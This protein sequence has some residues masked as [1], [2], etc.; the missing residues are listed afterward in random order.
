[1]LKLVLLSWLIL[2]WTLS[3]Q[4]DGDQRA[5]INAEILFIN[6]SIH[7]LLIAHRVYENYNQ[8]INKYVDL[9]SYEINK[10]G[11]KDLPKDIFEDPEHWFYERSPQE[12]YKALLL[13]ERRES[14]GLDTWPLIANIRNTGDF[15]NLKRQS[16]DAVI[17]KDNINEMA[18]IQQ[19]YT[20][21]EE[22]IDQYDRVRNSIK[23]FES[24][25]QPLYLGIELPEPEKAIYTTLVEIHYDIKKCLRNIRKDNQSGVIQSIGK[26]DTEVNW[27]SV[28]INKVADT[29]QKA[30]LMR[31]R[32]IIGELAR[33]IKAYLNG[34]NVPQEY[35]A[36][37]KGYYYHNVKLL[38]QVNRYGNGYVAEANA[39]FDKNLW[40]VIHFIEEP[41]YLKIVYPEKVPKEILFDNTIEPTLDVKSLKPQDLPE[42]PALVVESEI[43][44]KEE[45]P[46]EIPVIIVATHTI[47]VDSV[48]FELDL[49]DHKRKDGD[50]VSINVNGEW[51][52]QNISLEK[53]TQKIKLTIKPG[54]DNAIM[55]RADNEGWMPPNTVGLKYVGKSG[56]ENNQF[57]KTDLRVNEVLRI[58]YKRE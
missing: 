5:Y 55:I 42:I 35:G 22:A 17:K 46:K 48:T 50:R 26:I 11:N 6:E 49:L 29:G 10:Y 9:P 37:G 40:P 43:P 45:I 51:I 12:I 58:E 30:N 56:T 52:F 21:L 20:G 41:H 33:D 38:T 18:N 8:S 44:E 7:G 47:I 24:E 53:K 14:D 36:F 34:G 39:F 28:C 31:I 15:V 25:L 3:A 19:V 13:D 23:I 27:L 1:M 32:D 2:P 16:L 4:M 54:A 57:I